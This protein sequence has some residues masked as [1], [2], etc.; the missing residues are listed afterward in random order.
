MTLRVLLVD[1]QAM[2]RARLR[3]RCEHDG[4][5]AVVAEAADGAAAVALAR[6][7]RPDV[8][9]MDIQL[10]VLD[11][12]AATRHIVAEPDLGGRVRVLVLASYELDRYVYDALRA[13]ASGFLTKDAAPAVLRDA[14]RTVAAGQALLWPG[15][16]R[17]LIEAF[18]TRPSY[19]PDPSRLGVLT[20]REREI[21]SLVGQGLSNTDIGGRLFLSSATVKTHVNRTMSKLHARDRA[22]LVVI[23]YETGLVHPGSRP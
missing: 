13:G 17:S 19:R 5:L 2:V 10:P 9:L 8:V 11:G 7:H 4:D 16:T 23:A 1:D 20:Q 12:V 3:T 21:L 14:I 6:E 22:Q 18:V 15:A